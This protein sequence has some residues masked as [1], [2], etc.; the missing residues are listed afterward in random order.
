MFTK[1]SQKKLKLCAGIFSTIAITQL[2]GFNSATAA[3]KVTLRYG[4]LKESAS[5]ID[6]KKITE[7]GKFPDS[8]STFTKR[9]TE[10]QSNFLIRGLKA[11]IPLNVVTLNRLLD[12]QLG[13]T[14]LSDIATGLDRKDDAGVQAVRAGLILAASSPE[15]L[16]I[17]SFIEAY[18]S[19]SLNINVPQ[20]VQVGRILNM[21]FWRTQ[22]FMLAMVPRTNPREMRINRS[23]DPT[24]P[25]NNQVQILNL[26]LNDQQRQ[27]PIPVDIYWSNSANREKPV[28]VFSHGYGSVRTDLKYLAEHL[29][30]HGYVVAALEHPGSNFDANQG[31]DSLKAQEFVHRPQDVSFV[32]NELEKINQATDNPLQGK[33]A[34]NNIMVVGYSFG[35]TTALALAG[36]E[37]QVDSLKQSCAQRENKLNLVQGF[38]CRAKD[39]PEDIYQL[40]D[41]RV[42]KIVA[43]TPATSFLFGKSGLTKIQVP[44]LMLTGSTDNITPTLSEHIPSF[45]RIPSRKWLAAAVGATHLSV[46]DPSLTDGKPGES[47]LSFSSRE[48]VG[49]KAADVRNYTKAVTLAMAAQSTAEANQYANFLTSGYAQVASTRLFPF[50]L[51]TDIPPAA[52]G[53]MQVPG[54]N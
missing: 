53:L 1:K 38:M 16:S 51:L 8:I 21:G 28:I 44:T 36:G 54:Q 35:G 19:K 12:T 34:T 50:R 13:Q 29:T 25:G 9:L 46:V 3:E 22:Q 2:I 26:N 45:A 5:L 15:G 37:F 42:K 6:L 40:R 30:S 39:L 11:R 31:I 27:R 10:Q 48:V 23:F 17:L 24:K 52:M 47:K 4:P 33:L 49:D 14:I 7:N 18:P 41:E 32:I 20:A 43:L